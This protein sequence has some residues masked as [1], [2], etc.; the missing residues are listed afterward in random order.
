[1]RVT[2][3]VPGDLGVLVEMWVD[4]AADQREYGSHIRPEDNRKTI[5]NAL[6]HSIVVDEVLVA[7]RESSAEDDRTSDDNDWTPAKD[8]RTSDDDSET[9]DELLGFVQFSLQSNEYDQDCSRGLISNV[10]VRPEHRNSS[11]GTRLLSAA[12]TN[13]E[14]S[15]ADVVSLEAMAGNANARRFYRRHGYEAHR[16]VLEKSLAADDS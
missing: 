13:L 10:Y 11:I 5:R 16:I 9:A 1:M 8:D 2:P 7:R 14:N 4:L 3:A 15:G 6:A 12:E